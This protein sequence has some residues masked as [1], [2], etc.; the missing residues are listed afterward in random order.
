MVVN[1]GSELAVV[2]DVCHS[3][4]EHTF[5]CEATAGYLALLLRFV[6]L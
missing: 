3:F 1:F 5:L 4:F 2:V 6:H